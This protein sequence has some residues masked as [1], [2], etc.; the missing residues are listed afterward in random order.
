M[1]KVTLIGVL[2]IGFGLGHILHDD[3]GLV[4]YKC[5]HDSLFKNIELKVLGEEN[6]QKA[7][8]LQAPV[9]D[10]TSGSQEPTSQ[11][12]VVDGWHNIRIL[13]D[14]SYAEKLI[15]SNP[16]LGAK[17]Q[18]SIRLL[19]SV[20]NYFGKHMKVNYEK[21]MN[22]QG[23]ACQG[24]TIS[25]F[26]KPVDLFITIKPENNPQTQYFAAAAPCY[27]SARDYRPV[28]G[29][30]ILNF[31]FLQTAYVN[32]YLYFS[33]F[34]HEFTHILGFS[35]HLFS[36]YVLPGTT[37]IRTDVVGQLV[38]GNEQFSAIVMPE[39]VQYTRKYFDCSTI[40]GMPLENNGGEGSANSHWEKLFL[41]NEYMNPTVE[42]PGYLSE[43]TFTVLRASG[44]Y[45]IDSS[46]AQRY[47]WGE[48]SGCS[49]FQICPK[50]SGG[51]CKPEE[52]S[53]ARCHTEWMGQ[54]NLE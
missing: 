54:V 53:G 23:G 43:F 37:T 8:I 4:T 7:R 30:Y 13:L 14:F 28:I 20:R 48:L 19:E 38:I 11:G 27:L 40:N 21:V 15:K 2:F 17:Y 51:Y 26:T 52:S 36:K 31:A 34:A 44:W 18:M 3:N 22:F 41:P 29:A 25:N 33:T 47:D 50:N 5:V 10:K 35:K 1:L 42:N 9:S 24:N 6:P 45:Q 12:D 16:D 32:E 46:A 49:H 39:V